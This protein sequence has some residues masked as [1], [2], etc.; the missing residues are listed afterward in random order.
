MTLP[1]DCHEWLRWERVEKTWAYRRWSYQHLV[2]FGCPRSPFMTLARSVAGGCPRH[3]LICTSGQAQ[4]STPAGTLQGCLVQYT[5]KP[6]TQQ[7]AALE[8]WNRDRPGGQ[9]PHTIQ[10]SKNLT[11]LP[12]G[13]PT[14]LI[15]L[16]A[17]LS[18]IGDLAG[19]CCL[20]AK[21]RPALLFTLCSFF[22]QP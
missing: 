6:L 5:Q 16:L 13:S 4:G 15:S 20:V 8:D 11:L 1:K 2:S 18:A 14:S 17:L 3:L 7:R 21:D 9:A 10:S 22:P 12:T 19:A